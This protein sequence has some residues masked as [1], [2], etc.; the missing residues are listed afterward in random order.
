M[1]EAPCIMLRRGRFK[2]VYIHG[3]RDQL[4]DLDAD[5]GEWHNLV[6]DPAHAEVAASMRGRILEVFDPDDIHARVMA[7]YH[8]RMV[9]QDALERNG[10]TWDVEPRFDP[11]RDSIRKY[12]P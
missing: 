3:Y 10:T 12:L 6:D 8:R 1:V 5:P 11:T 7:S 4:F 9:V 2:H